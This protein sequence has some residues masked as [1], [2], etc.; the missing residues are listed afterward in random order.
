MDAAFFI[1]FSFY[2]VDYEDKHCAVLI[3]STPSAYWRDYDRL[4]R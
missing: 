1:K 4:F 3:F 2:L